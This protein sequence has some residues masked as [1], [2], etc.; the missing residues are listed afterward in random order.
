MGV[1][2]LGGMLLTISG[3]VTYGAVQYL[4]TRNELNANDRR[5]VETEVFAARRRV[6]PE[7]VDLEPVVQARIARLKAEG[8]YEQAFQEYKIRTRGD[9]NSARAKLEQE[10]RKQVRGEKQSCGHGKGL[11]WDFTGIRPTGGETRG[12]AAVTSLESFDSD[13]SIWFEGEPLIAGRLMYDA[14]VTIN[15]V[16]GRIDDLRGKYFKVRF[17]LEDSK[18]P[19]VAHL[20]GRSQVTVVVEPFLQ[21]TYKLKPSS[22]IVPDRTIYS[23]WIIENLSTGYRGAMYRGNP[24]E[25]GGT[26]TVPAQVLGPNGQVRVTFLNLGNPKTNPPF[27][28][29]VMIPHEDIGILYR[30]GSFEMNF[31]R[32]FVLI[33]L[34]IVFLS[35]VG[36]FAGSF[37]S[38]PVGT[39]ICFVIMIFAWGRNFLTEALKILDLPGIESGP[40]TI[41]GHYVQSIMN[42]ILPNFQDSSPSD[43]LS[44]GIYISWEFL[45]IDVSIWFVLR[46]LLVVFVA[47]LIFRKRELGRVQV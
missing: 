1:M 46:G 12:T 15:D 45:G 26:L 29:S 18:R 38:F 19:A 43:S 40:F 39:L 16:P 2:L 9:E 8:R 35:A 22:N 32:A 10:I 37:L 11:S 24:V 34:Q 14:P 42:V 20:S 7:P 41:V 31:A 13:A 23:Y 33:F 30:A 17:D 21:I 47:C 27:E 3:A 36:T 44:D 4:R 25:M 28:T 6:S 5:A